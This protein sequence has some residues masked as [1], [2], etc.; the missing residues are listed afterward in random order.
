MKIGY[1]ARLLAW[2]NFRGFH[3]YT[4]SLLNEISALG[5]EL[6]LYT[7]AAPIPEHLALFPSKGVTV[8]VAPPMRYLSWEQSWLPRQCEL[9]GVDLLHSPVNFGLPWRAP[10][11]QILTLHDAIDQVLYSKEKT[12]GG[13]LRPDHLKTV[14]H[15]WVARTRANHIVT[16]SQHAKG[17]LIQHLGIPKEKITVIYEAAEARFHSVISQQQR[18]EMRETY[19]LERPYVLYLGGWE[20]RKNV[21]FLI[22]AFA[23][24]KLQRVDLVLAGG[25]EVDQSRLKLLAGSLGISGNLKLTGRFD[26][27]NLPALYAEAL[28]FVHP[29]RYEGFGL[30]LCEAMAAGCPVLAAQS[31]CLPEIVGGGGD[32]FRLEQLDDLAHS[33][34]RVAEDLD[35]R[36]NLSRRAKARSADFSWRKAAEETVALYEKA[37]GK[38]ALQFA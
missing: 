2:N 16:V 9:D 23:A 30:Q 24:A 25:G 32:T 35:Y 11:P 8:R 1:N 6:F 31:T 26:E 34:E 5:V 12:F 3:R 36:A 17:D 13:R 33:L 28:C 38:P 22:E 29:S 37:T 7:D 27:E 18:R 14:A 21:P 4:I 10:C 15:Q 20:P 19:G